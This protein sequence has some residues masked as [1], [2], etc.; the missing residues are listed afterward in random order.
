MKKF[1]KLTLC[2]LIGVFAI[3]LTGCGNNDKPSVNTS[4]PSY[5]NGGMAVTSGGYVYFVNGY[6]SYKVYNKGNLSD[7]LELGGLYRAKLNENNQVTYD[8][9]G[10][11]ENV[12]RISGNLAGFENTSLYVFGDHIYYT[13]PKTTVDKSGELETSKINF[14]RMNLDGSN[15]TVMYTSKNEGEKIDFQYYYADG[16]V[17]LVVKEDTKLIKVNCWGKFKTTTIEEKVESVVLHTVEEDIFNSDAYQHLYYTTKTDD[18]KILINNYD[19]ATG[20]KYFG[21]TPYKTCEL[22]DYKF[23]HLYYKA[24]TNDYPNKTYIY[25]IDSTENALKHMMHEQISQTEYTTFYLLE[26]ESDGYIAQTSDKTYYLTYSSNGNSEAYP[27]ADSKLDIMLINNG[28]IYVKSSNDIKTINYL[29]CKLNPNEYPTQSNLITVDGMQTYGYDV[30][31][32]Y[33]YIYAKKGD[34]TYLYSVYINNPIDGENA[35]VKLLGTYLS[36]DVE[37]DEE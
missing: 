14:Y 25:R 3:G 17:Y 31:N 11:L 9:D 28:V 35:E 33:L 1:V 29:D 12:S 16:G 6:S 10:N 37:E 34:N 27:I 18:G 13:A 22:I 21:T 24:S 15:A 19:V 23:N 5:G 8:E 20:A 32:N 36:T 2:L 26:N 7:K 30:D 4:I